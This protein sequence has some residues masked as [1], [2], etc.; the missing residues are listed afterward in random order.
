[1]IWILFYALTFPLRLYQVMITYGLYIFSRIPLFNYYGDFVYIIICVK[2]RILILDTVLLQS[3]HD[4]F[5]QHHTN[6]A[7]EISLNNLK[8]TKYP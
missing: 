5:I 1:M 3:M 2:T 4:N 6:S 7:V 8:L